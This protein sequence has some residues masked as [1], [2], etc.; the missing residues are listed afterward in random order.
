MYKCSHCN[1]EIPDNQAE[2]RIVKVG[3]KDNPK[4]YC[5]E[6]GEPVVYIPD[7]PQATGGIHGAQATLISNSDNR[8]TTNNYYGNGTPDEQ[9]DTPYGPCSKSEARLCRQCRQWIPLAFF[10]MEKNLCDN[11]FEHEGTKAYE[12]GKM[13]FK[14]ELYDEALKEFIKF[15]PFPKNAKDLANLQYY[16][17]RCY[18]EQKQWKDALRY[19]VKSHENN[20]DSLFYMGLCFKSGNGVPKDE[21]KGTEYIKIAAQR[22]SKHAL[23]FIA[24]EELERKREEEEKQK[25]EKE[26][27][28]AI[29]SFKDKAY[30][31]YKNKE[32]LKAVDFY[33]DAEKIGY[34]LDS[35]DYNLIGVCYYQAERYLAALQYFCNAVNSGDDA[36]S[37]A[38]MYNI[39]QLY[40]YG[41]GVDE[42][43]KEAIN[44]YTKAANKGER[45]AQ[46]RLGLIYDKSDEVGNIKAHITH[47]GWVHYEEKEKYFPFLYNKKETMKWF[48]MAAEQGHTE[49]QYKLGQLL[50]YEKGHEEEGFK[51]I[52]KAAE[53]GLRSA[54]YS[55]AESYEDGKGIARNYSEALKWYKKCA[56][57]NDSFSMYE[58]GRY[59]EKGIGTEKNVYEAFKWYK[60]AA[61]KNDNAGKSALARCYEHGIG[62]T[63]NIEEAVKWYRKCPDYEAKEALKRLGYS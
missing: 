3:P 5:M 30:N 35:R 22:N 51:W 13:F 59:Y 54:Q 41:N 33:N 27:R 43:L 1:I 36:H 23:D 9:I 46:Y 14:M 25:K 19:F 24:S 20:A 39:G 29:E 15:V 21:N 60:K 37:I 55:T 4:C 52:L 62:V 6:C 18:Y 28:D 57:Q 53:N 17:G 58:V 10:N 11:C 34:Y 31:A 16:I 44:W 2:G 42:D 61:E 56:D 7:M 50:S 40:E 47:G 8:I 32:Y 48:R 49:A 12:E 26:R 63:R 38:A 45:S